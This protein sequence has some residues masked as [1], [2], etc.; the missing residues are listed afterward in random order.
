[1]ISDFFTKNGRIPLKREMYTCYHVA[2]NFYGTWNK[3]IEAA[4]FKPNP[5]MFSKKCIAKD[6]HKCDSL[7][8]KIIDDYLYSNK[9]IHVRNFQYP[10]NKKFTVDFKIED[11]WVEFFGLSGQLKRY[12]ELMSQKLDIVKRYKLKL[13]KLYLRDLF[14]KN[15]LSKKLSSLK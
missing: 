11:M 12:D 14:P 4:G 7:A 9:I 15:K 13:I 3:A 2:R 6:G 1:M 8:E 5:V 10:G